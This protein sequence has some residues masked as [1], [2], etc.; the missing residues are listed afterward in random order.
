MAFVHGKDTVVTLNAVDISAFSDNTDWERE[1]DEH[2]LTTY[3]KLAHVF[4]GGLLGGKVTVTG[5]YD[6][7]AAG[8]QATI[9]PLIGSVVTLIYKPAGTGVGRIQKSVSVLVKSY[10]ESDPVADFIKWTA[11]FTMSDVV[12]QTT[13]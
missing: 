2:D 3:G 4:K 10:K 13:Q 6:N 9:E 11:E 12:T 8:P 1:A 5:T 7:G